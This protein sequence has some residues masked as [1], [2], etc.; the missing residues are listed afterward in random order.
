MAITR[1]FK[2]TIQARVLRDPEFRT[3][4]LIEGLEL[5]INGDV[6]TGKSVLR[7]YINA[8]LGFEK[9]A[10]MTDKSPKSLMR[11]FST[12]G[13][14]TANNLLAVICTLQQQEG[15]QLHIESIH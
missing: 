6:E 14:P 2:Q 5:L 12:K 1:N 10:Q 9:L 13:N 15:V 8:T 7:D 3:A 4:L 11:M